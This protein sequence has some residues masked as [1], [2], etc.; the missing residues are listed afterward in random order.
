MTDDALE[1][2]RRAVKKAASAADDLSSALKTIRKSTDNVFKRLDALA[3]ARKACVALAGLPGLL[4]PLQDRITTLSREAEAEAERVRARVIGELDDALKQRGLKLEGR[5]PNLRC[6]PL[7]LEIGGAATSGMAIWYGPRIASMGSTS[8]DP[9]TCAQAVADTLSKLTGDSFD[10]QHFIADLTAAW[11][12]A[13]ARS[14]AQPG[15]RAPINAVLA[16]MAVTRQS[17]K[18]RNDPTRSGFREYTRVQFSFDLGRI[19]TRIVG[20]SELLLTV[21][22]RDQ[23]RKP[24]DHLWVA[25]THYAFLGFR[26]A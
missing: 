8:L 15:D 13:V 1:A 21:A 3:A 22:T 6:G 25:G 17:A 9:E 23:T 4:G 7:T 12:A 2:E 26:P 24:A 10:D 16:E 20:G 19:R 11:R 18:W 14:G 5:L